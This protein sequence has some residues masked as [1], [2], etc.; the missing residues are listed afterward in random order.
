MGYSKC[1]SS[2]MPLLI[3]ALP[4]P[5]FINILS[6]HVPPLH[7]TIGAGWSVRRRPAPTSSPQTQHVCSISA[8]HL[9][10]RCRSLPHKDLQ[11]L[12]RIPARLFSCNLQ[13]LQPNQ[14][15]SFL[16]WNNANIFTSSRQAWGPSCQSF[17]S[18]DWL[19]VA[20][21]PRPIQE[22]TWYFYASCRLLFVL[23]LNRGRTCICP[24]AVS[25]V[26]LQVHLYLPKGDVSS[27]TT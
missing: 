25:A 9:Q 1:I 26:Y 10:V 24:L 4:Y 12:C 27:E 11:V 18:L 2:Q 19:Q 17:I 21:L 22:S 14:E 6:S 20:G 3:E 16:H 23:R 8:T 13:V 7:S 15:L 5:I